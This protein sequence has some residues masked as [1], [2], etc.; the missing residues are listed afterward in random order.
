MLVVELN[1]YIDELEW[2]KLWYGG[3]AEDVDGVGINNSEGW[4]KFLTGDLA[5]EDEVKMKESAC[6]KVFCWNIGVAG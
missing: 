5:E 2:W 4:G 1:E 6:I 3:I